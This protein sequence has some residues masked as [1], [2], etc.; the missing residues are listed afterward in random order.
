[1]KGNHFRLQIIFIN[2]ILMTILLI[3][4]YTVKPQQTR[5]RQNNS[6]STPITAKSATPKW[7]LFQS[8]DGDFT[9]EFPAQPKRIQDL[10]GAITVVRQYVFADN[11]MWLGIAFE[12]YGGK[13]DSPENNDWGL[14]FEETFS[15]LS[16]ENG[17]KI[18]QFR[19]LTK[20]TYE[21][22]AWTPASTPNDYQ[23]YLTRATLRNARAYRMACHSLIKNQQVNKKVC[24][25]FFD[26]FRLRG[27]PH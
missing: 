19:R 3:S 27:L 2:R 7:F 18:V 5:Q 17:T 14:K 21:L 15:R 22:E 6:L 11:I 20:S 10:Q 13:P 8:P 9:L 24:R 4:A 25:R 1:M 16:R 26:S 12:D 23:H